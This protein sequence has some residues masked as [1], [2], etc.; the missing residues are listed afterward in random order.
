MLHKLLNIEDFS[1][2]YMDLVVNRDSGS[3]VHLIVLD[4][5]ICE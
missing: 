1:F 2:I 3:I 4:N 5:S